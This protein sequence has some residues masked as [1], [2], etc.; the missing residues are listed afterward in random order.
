MTNGKGPRFRDRGSGAE[1]RG[2]TRGF[3]G[4][5]FQF[6]KAQDA[7]GAINESELNDL[8]P[9]HVRGLPA[10]GD[11]LR[12]VVDFRRIQKGLKLI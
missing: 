8:I 9:R 5:G 7:P 11:G 10:F 12:F 6:G 1:D 4:S 3:Q 2:P